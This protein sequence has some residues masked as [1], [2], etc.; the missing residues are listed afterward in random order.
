[1]IISLCIL[2]GVIGSIFILSLCKA[3]GRADALEEEMM[4]REKDV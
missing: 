2:A 1:M 4:K 3:A